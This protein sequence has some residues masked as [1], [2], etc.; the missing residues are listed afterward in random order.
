MNL[1]TIANPL[2]SI[3]NSSKT[4][5][6]GAPWLIAHKTMLGI[7]KPYKITF[8]GKDY[9]LWQN[10]QQEIFALNN[11][12]PHMQ[13]PLSDGW[14]CRERNTI[15][16]PFHG[17]EFDGKG[18]VYREENLNYQ[19]ITQPLELIVQDE[20][21]WTYGG[22]KPRLP[23]PD[24]IPRITEGFIFLGAT[25]EKSIQAD[26]LK[27]LKINYDFN[28]ALATHR[29]P[30]KFRKIEIKDYQENNYYTKLNQEITRADNTLKEIITNPAFLTTPKTLFNQFEYSF[31]STTSI[32]TNT[33][34]GQL[35]QLFILYPETENCTKT[36]I[37]LYAKPKNIFNKFLLLLLKQYFLN[38]F[39]LIFEQD[40]NMLETLYPTQ[41]PKIRLPREEIMF[42]AEKL[43]QQWEL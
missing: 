34:F 8:Q 38:S 9:V 21:I 30:F 41:K 18:R 24:L 15:T 10:Q 39:N 19:A 23:I 2:P 26:F 31:P 11:I 32:I 36:F 25:G 14:V 7:N 43:Y 40:T 13:A 29:E 5:L 20:L 33:D 6:P 35:V 17:L 22:I 28:H 16:C 42:H 4:I 1:T 37:L 27:C 12:C 3:N